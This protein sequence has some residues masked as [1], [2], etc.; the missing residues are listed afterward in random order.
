MKSLLIVLSAVLFTTSL[1]A[2]YTTYGKIEYERKSN[3]HQQLQDMQDGSDDDGWIISMKAQMPKYAIS[4]F[5]YVFTTKQSLY[6]P[7]KESINRYKGWGAPPAMDN[8]VFTDFQTQKVVADKQVYEEKFLVQDSMRK[9]QWKIGDEIRMIANYKCRKAITRLY[10][11]VVVVA[12]YTDDIAV[13]GGPEL[14]SGLPGAILQITIPRLHTT[15][16]ATKIELTPPIA[17]DFKIPTKGKKM[18]QEE[19][20]T[21]LSKTVSKWGNWGQRSIWWSML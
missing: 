7:G 8:I 9:L 16:M 10:D 6:K 15:W 11:S 19:L 17:E 20:F 14:F 18:T 13:S 5:D 4:Y 1:Q 3:T 2:Q 12:F 21:T